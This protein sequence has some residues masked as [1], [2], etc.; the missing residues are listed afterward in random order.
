MTIAELKH[1]LQSL[2]NLTAEN[3]VVEF[4]ETKMT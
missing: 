1:I 4:K 2:H 3:V